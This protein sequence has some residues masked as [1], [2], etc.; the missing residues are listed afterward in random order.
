MATTAPRD[1]ADAIRRYDAPVQ[2]LALGLRPIVHDELTPCFEYVYEMKSG[3]SLLYSATRKPIADGMCYIG[4]HAKHVTLGFMH[5][6]ELNDPRRLLLGA[7]KVMRHV[8]ISDSDDVARPEL[9]QFLRQARQLAGM[10][11]KKAGAPVEITLSVK[12]RARRASPAPRSAWPD[13][14]F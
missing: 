5:G 6:A 4:L 2:E 7:G 10:P 12:P 11:K 8:R 1:I 3:V 13:R 14:F 9:R